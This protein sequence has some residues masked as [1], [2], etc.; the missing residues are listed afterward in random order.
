MAG[1]MHAK[2]P[3]GGTRYPVREAKA[4]RAEA[5]L[6]IIAGLILLAIGFPATLVLAA[7]ALAPDGISPLIAILVGA[8]FIVAGWAACHYAS[9]RLET[10]ARL[11]R[12]GAEPP[13]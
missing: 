4:L 8:P 10:A 2:A 12:G 11:T 3:P 7:M 13:R 9:G 5:R 1:A 6:L